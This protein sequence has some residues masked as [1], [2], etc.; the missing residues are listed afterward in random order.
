MNPDI[1]QDK[2]LNQG[3]DG[4][5]RKGAGTE[6]EAREEADPP[7]EERSATVTHLPLPDH[8]QAA[9]AMLARAR[10]A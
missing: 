8:T 3:D 7:A 2:K 1:A 4:S 6:P 9:R 10:R 5:E